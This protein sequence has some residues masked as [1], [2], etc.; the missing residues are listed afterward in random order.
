MKK[1]SFL[2]RIISLLLSVVFVCSLVSCKKADKNT[3]TT[4][5]NLT[6][7]CVDLVDRTDLTTT[8]N[9]S[10]QPP[11]STHSTQSTQST[12]TTQKQKTE[13]SKII[14]S[15]L[16]EKDKENLC[17]FFE[18]FTTAA[19]FHLPSSKVNMDD[20]WGEYNVT[21]SSKASDAI[22]LAYASVY[23]VSFVTLF[24]L[25]QN[26][27]GWDIDDYVIRTD[28]EKDPQKKFEMLL[29]IKADKFDEI[30]ETVFNVKA[31]RKYV[32]YDY[33]S[34]EKQ[35]C[36][37]YEGEWFYSNWW[38]GGDG[39]GPLVKLKSVNQKSDGKYDV[40]AQLYFGNDE[41]YDLLSSFKAEV[42]LKEYN[43]SRIWSLY[44]M[45]K[46]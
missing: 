28:N 39:A 38:E 35:I 31:D 46:Q 12:K 18:Y 44:S 27:Y 11:Q 10:T 36:G 15:A 22:D 24:D 2:N 33:Q 41:G 8:E 23:G 37:Y 17:S 4:T 40:T 43:G 26:D 1:P 30:L 6:M 19:S 16:K 42:A 5:E 21:Y 34:E 20:R 25:Y 7:N 29:K 32:L 14:T 9:Q 45:E 3:D 13:K